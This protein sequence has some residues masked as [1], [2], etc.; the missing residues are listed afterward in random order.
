MG[1]SRLKA[2]SRARRI[3]AGFAITVAAVGCTGESD[4]STESSATPLSE[5]E[6]V[7]RADRI[8]LETS[9]TSTSSRSPSAA[10]S[11]SGSGPSCAP[12]Q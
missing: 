4:T 9:V 8:C 10:R 5:S 12:G 11:P 6:F 3:L 1:T 7:V 2:R